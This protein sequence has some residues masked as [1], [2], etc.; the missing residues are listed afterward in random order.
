M[1]V[2]VNSAELAIP[3]TRR[4]ITNKL[5]SELAIQW[6]QL[7]EYVAQCR[8]TFKSTGLI[9]I[10]FRHVNYL[11]E[12][13]LLAF[14]KHINQRYKEIFQQQHE[15]ILIRMIELGATETALI[16]RYLNDP[17][18]AFAKTIAPLLSNNCRWIIDRNE[19]DWSDSF[20]VRNIVGNEDIL[21]RCTQ[22]NHDFW[23]VDTGY[24]NFLEGKRKTWHRLL[25]NNLH[26][27]HV[28]KQ[29]PTDRIGLL[30]D[31][32]RGWR[33]KGSKILVI[34]N[35]NSHYCMKGTTL[36]AWRKYVKNEIRAFSDRP[37]EFRPKLD[38][39]QRTSV[40]E[41]LAN[42]KDYYCVVSDSS[43]A[44]VEA[45]WAGVPVV[46][47]SRHITNSVSRNDFSQINDLYRGPLEHWLAM[48]T[49]SQWTFEELC[50]GTA[51]AL[52]RE[53]HDV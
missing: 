13:D 34:E 16:K 47:L 25:H 37:V 51:V 14:R 45:I 42:T 36:E 6:T 30:S 11:I 44:A 27:G 29:F 3:V 48:L 21:L 19:I 31:L 2:I 26:H 7:N 5:K 22:N 50:D 46:T 33:K 38:R 8:D 9:V 40:Y 35:S 15:Q 18:P 49:Y 10:D 23:F 32:P 52:T 20:F 17:S 43:A 24:T 39:K 1:N 4:T 41:L 28:T 12:R 53:W